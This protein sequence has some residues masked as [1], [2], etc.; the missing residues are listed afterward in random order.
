MNLNRAVKLC[1]LWTMIYCP[2]KKPL[3]RIRNTLESLSCDCVKA[4]KFR[5]FEHSLA[6]A[7]EP[8]GPGEKVRIH[9]SLTKIYLKDFKNPSRIA[10]HKR[11]IAN[12]HYKA[13]IEDTYLVLSDLVAI[14][15]VVNDLLFD[16]WVVRFVVFSCS[17]SLHT[18]S[19]LCRGLCKIP[20]WLNGP[21]ALKTDGTKR[22]LF[23]SS[24]P[25]DKIRGRFLQRS[26]NG[27]HQPFAI[28]VYHCKFHIPN[29]IR[30]VNAIFLFPSSTDN[31]N[32]H[33]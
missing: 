6:Y 21:T 29:S 24:V 27:K 15:P 16:W 13:T 2:R 9:I 20:S 33:K 28:L 5:S 7:R 17:E 30:S 19:N 26:R 3:W 11:S 1:K 32:T 23:S 10:I 12:F 31:E 4:W 22:L 18:V 14:F 8:P 25:S